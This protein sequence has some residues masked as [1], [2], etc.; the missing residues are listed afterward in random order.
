MKRTNRPISWTSDLMKKLKRKV[1]NRKCVSQTRIFKQLSITQQISH[2]LSLMSKVLPAI[3]P[4]FV[5]FY[6]IFLKFCEYM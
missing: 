5:H 4:S 1:K 3:N 6:P 2:H